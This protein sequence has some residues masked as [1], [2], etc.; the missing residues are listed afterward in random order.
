MFENLDSGEV[1]CA[2]CPNGRMLVTAGT[3]TVGLTTHYQGPR[4]YFFRPA[5]SLYKLYLRIHTTGCKR[6]GVF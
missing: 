5:H 6:L 1:L 3:S 4:F 2:A